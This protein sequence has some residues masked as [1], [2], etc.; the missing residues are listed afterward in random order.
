MQ[1]GTKEVEEKIK[2]HVDKKELNKALLIASKYFRK[3]KIF[4][5]I[6]MGAFWK[7]QDQEEKS[8]LHYICKSEGFQIKLRLIIKF[9]II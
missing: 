8:P 9:V 1:N 5:S 6:E 4:E 3:K 2:E 7:A